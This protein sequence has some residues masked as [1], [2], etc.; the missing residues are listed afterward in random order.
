M[1]NYKR[2]KNR[3]HYHRRKPKRRKHSQGDGQSQVSDGGSSAD[4]LPH[5]G[6]DVEVLIYTYTRYKRA[7]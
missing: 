4:S 7:K 1:G 6:E 5:H 2:S 3:R